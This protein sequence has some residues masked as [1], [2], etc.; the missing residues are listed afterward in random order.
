VRFAAEVVEFAGKS[1]DAAT[2]NRAS[3]MWP[4]RGEALSRTLEA[5]EVL[6]TLYTE[7]IDA[8]VTGVTPFVLPRLT[9]AVQ[10]P[11]DTGAITGQT[12]EL[13][14]A[15]DTRI[16]AALSTLYALAFVESAEGMG[17]ELPE[18]DLRTKQTGRVPHIPPRVVKAITA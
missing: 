7:V 6:T 1:V 10:P 8:W 14:R 15:L 18:L 17:I 12:T 5:E 2:W 3:L 4:R 13:D 9:A 16:L 11:P